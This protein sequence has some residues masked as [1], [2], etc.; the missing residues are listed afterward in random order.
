MIYVLFRGITYTYGRFHILSA[1][2]LLTSWPYQTDF[3]CPIAIPKK[4]VSFDAE[5]N[6][7]FSTNTHA[8]PSR[9]NWNLPTLRE[10]NPFEHV[11]QSFLFF[12]RRVNRYYFI[13]DHS[14]KYDT[15][16]SIV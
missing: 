8:N 12:F 3:F 7:E 15:F 13:R 10:K 6:S 14:M 9:R 11:C 2:N 4:I 16:Y 5:F 1:E